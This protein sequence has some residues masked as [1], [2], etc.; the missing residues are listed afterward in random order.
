MAI[1]I[2]S[3]VDGVVV[4]VTEYGAIVRMQG[5]KTGLIHISEIAD[6]FV[7]DV[8][9]YFKEHDRVRV[10]VLSVNSKGRYELSTKQVEQPPQEPPE[11]REREKSVERPPEEINLGP[12]PESEPET[13]PVAQ[14]FEER[15]SRFVKESEERL[16]QLKRNIESKR[17]NNRRR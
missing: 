17:G 14:S 4:K 12:E 7:R 5:G 16:L 13:T 8:K 3:T 6:T 11:P 9:D 2:G 10:R 15:L 1:E